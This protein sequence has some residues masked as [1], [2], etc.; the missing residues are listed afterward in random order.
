[1]VRDYFDAVKDEALRAFLYRAVEPCVYLVRRETKKVE[2]GQS[3]LEGHP[4]LPEEIDWPKHMRH[5]L[6]FLAQINLSDIPAHSTPLPDSGMLYF[7]Y[8]EHQ[9]MF[10]PYTEIIYLSD[11][12]AAPRLLKKRK[13]PVPRGSFAVPNP[14]SVGLD[15]VPGF[16][17]PNPYRSHMGRYSNIEEPLFELY[18]ALHEDWQEQFQPS[19][20][21]LFG[22]KNVRVDQQ[23]P[24]ITQLGHFDFGSELLF[25]SWEYSYLSVEID[26]QALERLDF[27]NIHGRIKSWWD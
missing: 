9:P 13:Q 10:D 7:F 4:H 6:T 11:E 22:H 27:S 23:S 24:I 19:T 26:R 17:L 1:M 18:Y 16:T 3:C 8:R 2:L 15:L 14:N 12:A 20:H 5:P 25:E 21:W